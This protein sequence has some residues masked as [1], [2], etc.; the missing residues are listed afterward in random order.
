MCVYDGDGPGSKLG[1]QAFDD[2]HGIQ[3]PLVTKLE[4]VEHNGHL[5]GRALPL[6]DHGCRDGGLACAA[7]GNNAEGARIAC[8]PLM[9]LRET[10]LR[11]PR[12]RQ[13]LLSVH[14]VA[15]RLQEQM[16]LQLVV[17]RLAAVVVQRNLLKNH[18]LVLLLEALGFGDVDAG[19]Q[20][21]PVRRGVERH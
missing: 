18:R 5:V 7:L 16:Q 1:S 11:V 8:H 6:S 13:V 9:H 21:T 12:P 3:A 20:G 15:Q 19:D 10:P 17:E 2:A 14:L 4:V